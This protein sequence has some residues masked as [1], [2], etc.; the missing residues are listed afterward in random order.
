MQRFG[1]WRFTQSHPFTPPPFDA[2]CDE[3]EAFIKALV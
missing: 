2:A 3:E 1:F